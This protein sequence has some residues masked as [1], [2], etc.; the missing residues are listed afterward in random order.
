[1]NVVPRSAGR[2][3]L[4]AVPEPPAPAPDR[5]CQVGPARAR[6]QCTLWWRTVPE[7]PGERVGLLGEFHAGDP[8]AA[9]QVLE[10]ACTVLLDKGCT[11]AVGP[12]DGSTWHN[13]RFIVD[14]GSAPVFFLEPRHPAAYPGYFRQQGFSEFARYSSR[15]QDGLI[16]QDP[17]LPGVARRMQGLGVVIR[18]LETTRM[19]QE[20]RSIHGVATRAFRKNFLYTP[21]PIGMFQELYAP[22]FA[23]ADPELVLLACH[24]QEV[25]GFVFGIPDHLATGNGRPITTLIVK[26]LAVVPGRRYAGLGKLPWARLC[27]SA[28]RKGYVQAINALM[29]DR[30][31]S[32]NLSSRHARLMR[33]YA[34]FAKRLR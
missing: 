10:R 2:D 12:M 16:L 3:L 8:K 14:Q 1:M 34:L 13:Y 11:L 28:S 6:G 30:G 19:D 22:L 29:H 9:Q 21:I 7:L 17:R 24:E 26:T 18:T 31:D 23:I 25:I 33:S 4:Q 27:E 20:L 32:V 15:L 5:I